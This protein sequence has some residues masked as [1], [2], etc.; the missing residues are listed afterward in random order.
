MEGRRA[1]I[2][3]TPG[4]RNEL[5][6]EQGVPAFSGVDRA[7]RCLGTVCGDMDIPRRQVHDDLVNAFTQ[8]VGNPFAVRA[9]VGLGDI[10]C[11]RRTLACRGCY[12]T[13]G[14]INYLV[15]RLAQVQFDDRATVRGAHARIRHLALDLAVGVQ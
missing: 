3:T 1:G 4:Q 7:L 2:R 14:G 6:R 10:A 5:L 8:S 15:C 11:V 12:A 9:Y 13:V